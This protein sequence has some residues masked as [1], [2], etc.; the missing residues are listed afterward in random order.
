[1]TEILEDDL[2][3]VL[4]VFAAVQVLHVAGRCVQTVIGAVVL[5]VV[6]VRQFVGD[7]A[8]ETNRGLKGPA[9]SN[10]ADSVT[11]AS[12]DEHGDVEAFYKLDTIGVT[13]DREIEA[14]ETV[15]G[16]RI[17]SALHDDGLRFVNLDDLGD[18][19]LE[20]A[21]VRFVIDSIFQW[22]VD[23]VILALSDSN[24]LDVTCSRKV[25]AKLVEGDTHHT[26]GGVE[27][28]L[29]SI[30]VV[31]VDVN[32]QHP[33][34]DLEEFED[35]ED[36]VVDVTETGSLTL[37]GVMQSSSPVDSNVAILLVQL[38]RSSN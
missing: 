16:K 8:F 28:L 6:V 3:A 4:E 35:G 22:E 12:E 15:S 5:H 14:A 38:Y 27:G 17:C 10:V 24:I 23:R 30:T 31:N 32:V 21:F 9:T 13:L 29:D 2:L 19:G 7:L 37:F 1:M 34:V 36:D 18:D 20:D 26:I 11:T 25:L 33:L